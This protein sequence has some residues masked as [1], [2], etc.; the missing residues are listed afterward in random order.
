MGGGDKLQLVVGGQPVL[1]Y[2][3]AVFDGHKGIDA[4]VV[5]ASEAN[6]EAVRTMASEFAKVRVVLGGMR[7]RD[8]V[9]CGLEALEEAAPHPNLSPMGRG[10]PISSSCTMGHGRW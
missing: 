3:L 1:S 8:S 4:V 5:V 7:R 6:V 10:N 2:S 9:A